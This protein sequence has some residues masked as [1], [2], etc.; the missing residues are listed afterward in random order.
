MGIKEEIKIIS[1]AIIRNKIISKTIIGNKDNII[2]KGNKI[3]SQNNQ[4]KNFG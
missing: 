2:K 3:I 1:K 4:N